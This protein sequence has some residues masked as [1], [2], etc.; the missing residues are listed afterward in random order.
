MLQEGNR[1]GLSE[2]F[3]AFVAGALAALPSASEALYHAY[4]QKP[5]VPLNPLHLFEVIIV[6][7][8]IVLAIAMRVIMRRRGRRVTTLVQEIRARTAHASN[9][10]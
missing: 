8:C 9:P 6:T 1:D 10:Q 2:A 4:I 7:G 5:P 3:W